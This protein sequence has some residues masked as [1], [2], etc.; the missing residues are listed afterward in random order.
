MINPHVKKILI[1][2]SVDRR[3][4]WAIVRDGAVAEFSITDTDEPKQYFDQETND[5]T[6]ETKR[7]TLKLNLDES[8]V[9]VVAENA[10]YRC[11]PWSQSVYLCT[12]KNE[13]HMS[14]NNVLTHVSDWREREA[15]GKL[16]D[17]GL[18]YESFE[19]CI[20][21]NDDRLHQFLKK[22]EGNY[23]ID[24]F[25]CIN[26]IKKF[27]PVRLFRTKCA[28]IMVKQKIPLQIG[29]IDGPHTHLLPQIILHKVHFPIP[30]DDN[31][32]VQIQVDPFGSVIDA[33][34]NF[35][36]WT[37][38]ENDKFQ[39]LLRNYGESRVIE[40]KLKMRNMIH[41]F[42]KKDDLD[43]IMN[44]YKND[45]MKDLI[46]VILAQIVCDKN[47]D[48]SLRKKALNTLEQI[49]AI[50]FYVL[51]KWVINKCPDLL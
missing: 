38:S 48:R 29:E 44:I 20:I 1:E 36:D 19:A 7:A 26:E 51:K 41:D 23:I 31:M 28:S 3:S 9:A 16:W 46:R 12:P 33:C 39:S 40:D 4:T 10:T 42:L 18:G 8:V 43:S 50:N 22:R 25:E 27:S 13:S 45:I 15:D 17:L 47:Y 6:V 21:V 5:L 37:G 24:D 35:L 30:I 2:S 14:G 49:R 34:G 11:S 32:C